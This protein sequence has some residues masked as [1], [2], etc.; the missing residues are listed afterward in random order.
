MK[1]EVETVLPPIKWVGG[2]RSLL[3]EILPRIKKVYAD[4]T[5]FEPFVGGGAVFF[6]LKPKVAFISD[7]NS[8][9][10][11]FYQT[12]SDDFALLNLINED[13]ETYN[14]LTDTEQKAYFYMVRER[15][16]QRSLDNRHAADF[17]LL[18]KLGFNGL[19]RENSS[20]F[21]N[22]PFGQRNKLPVPA[23]AN[24]SAAREMLHSASPQTLPFEDSCARAEKGDFVY[25][26]PPYIPLTETASFT[27]YSA[28]GFGLDK[29]ELL[30]EVCREL[31]GKGTN[32]LLSNS[33]TEITREIFN[34]FN[35]TQI[36]AQR[37]V[38]AKSSSRVPVGELLI[39]NFVQS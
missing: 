17:Y 2:K 34:G 26:D 37:L 5:Y 13:A 3:K 18:N 35:F 29:Q 1:I 20:G 32:F 38:S 10:I 11:H 14:S 25:F 19:Y 21:Y 4:G 7:S 27:S 6:G 23:F 30:A 15:F 28:S 9:L 22:T 24:W 39:S 31:K 36:S 12:M 33:D 8:S 16:N